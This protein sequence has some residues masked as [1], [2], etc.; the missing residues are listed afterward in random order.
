MKAFQTLVVL[1]SVLTAG[2][3]APTNSAQLVQYA[4]LDDWYVYN[5]SFQPSSCLPSL[6]YHFFYN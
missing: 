4:N 3:A 2:F 6:N 1:A 5:L